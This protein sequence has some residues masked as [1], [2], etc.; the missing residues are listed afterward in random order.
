MMI[1]Q[2]LH[3][4]AHASHFLICSSSHWLKLAAVLKREQSLF[5]SVP[6]RYTVTLSFSEH[7]IPE[8]QQQLKKAP[9]FQ[10]M[11]FI[12][13]WPPPVQTCRILPMFVHTLAAPRLP[14]AQSSLR[15]FRPHPNHR[16]PR[17][18]PVSLFKEKPND[19]QIIVVCWLLLTKQKWNIFLPIFSVSPLHFRLFLIIVRG[20]KNRTAPE[21]NDFV[22]SS[23]LF[24]SPTIQFPQNGS[25]DTQL[26][27]FRCRHFSLS[28]L[29]MNLFH[30]PRCTSSVGPFCW[31][32]L[33][34]GPSS[35]SFNAVIWS[36]LTQF[37]VSRPL[38]SSDPA[39]CGEAAI[40][41]LCPLPIR[42][43]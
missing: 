24:G 28:Q 35:C 15:I 4:L 22:K 23:P 6:N 25:N 18:S 7:F 5:L 16:S 3:L 21:K 17:N 34:I 42:L 39:S 13:V 32:S 9:E 29:F 43:S 26:P 19:K 33:I 20:A 12:E 41:P 8:K 1:D 40:L 2:T 37:S 31:G 10:W 38:N 36:L 30:L 14:Y 11:L 27:W